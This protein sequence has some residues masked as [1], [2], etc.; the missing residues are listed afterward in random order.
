[1]R[2][3]GENGKAPP[4]PTVRC[5]IYTRKSS[6]EGLAQEFNSLDAQREAAE[7]YIAS[8]K[9]EGWIALPTRYDD[10]GYT[11]G[12]IDRPALKTLLSD[13]EAGKIDCIVVY[14]VDRL[15]RSLMDFAR[16]MQTFETHKVSFVSVTQ[17][18][19]TTHSMGRLTLNILLSFAQF[20]R[21]IIGER[22]RDKIA[23]SRAKGKW[24]GGTPIL[25]YDVDR[26]NGSPKL[27]VN[28]VES[29]RVRQIFELYLECGSLLPAV[30]ELERRNW[31]TK[32]WATR[33]KKNRGGVAFDKCSLHALLTNIVY[34]GKVRHKDAIYAGEH[35][36]II[37]E[38]LFGRVQR[39]LQQNGRTGNAEMRNRHGALLRGLLHCKACGRS[40]NHTFT[41]RDNR[42]YRYYTCANVIKGGRR[43]C[44]TPSLPAAEIEKAVVDQIRCIGQDPGLIAETLKQTRAQ[45]EAAIA[46]LT[47]ER[48]TLE[49]GLTRCHAKIRKAATGSVGRAVAECIAELTDQIGQAERRLVEIDGQIA[50]HRDNLVDEQDVAA[51][52][53]DFDNLWRMLSPR[54]QARVIHLLVSRVEFDGDDSTIEV[55]FHPSGIKALGD[56]TRCDTVRAREAVA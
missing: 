38:D 16:I 46:G 36:P 31:R 20:E 17:H 56:D 8:Q 51:A 3:K 10:G 15:S 29:S 5:A 27:V 52:L 21:E 28:A 33:S 26:S 49:N 4:P 39:K 2:R 41:S 45:A 14:K 37:P 42:R 22:I 25:G 44:P 12:N 30:A 32:V 43:R 35:E 11:G 48:R 18:F 34:F 24:T 1:M 47:G 50:E 23:A 9:A 53:A 13:I 55:A 6:E 54:E 40:M 19:N 7:A